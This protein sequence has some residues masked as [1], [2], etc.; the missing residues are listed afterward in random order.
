MPDTDATTATATTA[1]DGPAAGAAPED[2]GTYVPP[3]LLVV[4]GLP[5]LLTLVWFFL[6]FTRADRFGRVDAGVLTGGEPEGHD[7]EG[8]EEEDRDPP[9]PR[10]PSTS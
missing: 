3:L 8:A 4:F 10:D 6:Q 9:P 2:D 7:E 1:Q 5:I